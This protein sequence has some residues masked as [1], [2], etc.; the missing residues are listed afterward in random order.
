MSLLRLPRVASTAPSATSRKMA[1]S[2]SF[3]VVLPLLPVNA[4]SG[5]V[6]RLRHAY[7]SCVSP[8]RVLFTTIHGRSAG[9]RAAPSTSVITATAPAACAAPRY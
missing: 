6:K 5:P 2:I 4:T 1:A 3:T 9:A 8:V 7:A